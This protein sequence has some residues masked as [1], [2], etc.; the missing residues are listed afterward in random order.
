MVSTTS[1]RSK[2]QPTFTLTLS[3]PKVQQ[4]PIHALITPLN[5]AA[6]NRMQAAA[7][8]IYSHCCLPL[9]HCSLL[10][11]IEPLFTLQQAAPKRQLCGWGTAVVIA[12]A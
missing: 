5:V 3:H 8:T 9:C 2:N 4:H 10:P 6:R 1:P 7:Q 12:A 11:P